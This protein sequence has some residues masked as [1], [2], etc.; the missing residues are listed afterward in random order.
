M[1]VQALTTLTEDE[2]MFQKLYT[3]SLEIA[4]VLWFRKWTKKHRLKKA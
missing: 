2:K 1:T 3:V 4:S